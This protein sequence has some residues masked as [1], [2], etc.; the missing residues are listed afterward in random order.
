[1]DF[2]L[3]KGLLVFGVV[4]TVLY[5]GAFGTVLVRNLLA[6]FRYPTATTDFW[7]WLGA[8]TVFLLMLLL[9]VFYVSAPYRISF[10]EWGVQVFSWRGRIACPWSA[11]RRASLL[12]YKGNVEFVLFTG[13]VRRFGIPLSSYKKQATLFAEVTRWLAVPVEDPGGHAAKLTDG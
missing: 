10:S 13:R 9:F 4:V 8:A 7:G 3:S 2:E 11:F 12:S 5:A 1:M 6:Q